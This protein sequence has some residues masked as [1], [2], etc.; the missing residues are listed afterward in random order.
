MLTGPYLLYKEGGRIEVVIQ[1]D[2]ECST[3]NASGG[4]MELLVYLTYLSLWK[5]E[6]R[7]ILRAIDG[8]GK[9]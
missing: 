4:R 8:Y 6:W 9:S 2:L 3:K 7:G 5:P 1:Y